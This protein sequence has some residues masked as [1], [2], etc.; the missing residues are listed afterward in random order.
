MSLTNKT[1]K[2]KHLPKLGNKGRETMP[3]HKILNEEYIIKT[4]SSIKS[5]YKKQARAL[6]ITMYYTGAKPNEVLQLKAKDIYKEK[7]YIVV[8]IKGSK[9][10]RERKMYLRYK[11]KLI[12]ELYKYACS[13]PEDIILFYKFRNRYIK[14]DSNISITDRLRYYFK[15]WFNGSITPYSFVHNRFIKLGD[16]GLGP[17]ELMALKGSVSPTSVMKY[18]KVEAK[19]VVKLAKAID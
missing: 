1:D 7:S 6:I 3:K 5:K 4:I 8:N 17:R 12:K 14:N 16:K 19:E 15:K 11:H 13:I 9:G 18:V 10:S 2:R